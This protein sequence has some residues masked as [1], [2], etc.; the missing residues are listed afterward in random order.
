MED[1]RKPDPAIK[2]K[3]DYKWPEPGNERNCPA[4][5]T[6]PWQLNEDDPAYY[7]KPWWCFKCQFQF[8]EEDLTQGV[9]CPK[10]GTTRKAP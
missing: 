2:F 3:P 10:N 8:S 9:N 7:G 6:I 1:H 5:P 4:D